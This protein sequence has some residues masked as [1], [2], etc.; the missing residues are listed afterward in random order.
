MSDHIRLRTGARN[1]RRCSVLALTHKSRK[2]ERPMRRLNTAS[3]AILGTTAMIISV[4]ASPAMAE[5]TKAK[6][7]MAK[8]AKHT[9]AQTKGSQTLAQ[10][11]RNVT[12]SHRISNANA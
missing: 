12:R 11:Q 7:T 9:Q 4:L 2:R 6:G 10:G 3:L 8:S 5:G 1:I